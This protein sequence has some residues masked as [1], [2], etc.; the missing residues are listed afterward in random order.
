MAINPR[1]VKNL[2]FGSRPSADPSKKQFFK[3]KWFIITAIVVFTLLLVGGAF[4]YRT[5]AVLSKTNGKSVFN[6]LLGVIPGQSEEVKVEEDGRLNILLLGMRGENIPG[7]GLLA[8]SIMLISLNTKENKMAMISIP[9]DL[10]VKVPG[11]DNRAKINAVHA[12]GE[13]KGKGQGLKAM[14]DIIGQVTGLKVNYAVSIN[15]VGFKQLIDTVGGVPINLETP[16]YETHQFVEGKECGIEFNLPKGANVLNG[17]MALCYARAR[18]NTSDFDRSKRQQVILLALKE[19]L[20]SMGT[21]TDF[22][23]VNEILNAIGD[24]VRTDLSS[25]EMKSLYEKYSSAKDTQPYR[26][27]LENSEEGLLYHPED[28]NGAGYIL[29]PRAGEDNYSQIHEM[30]QNIYNLPVQSDIDPL[31]QHSKPAATEVNQDEV[32]TKKKKKKTESST[33]T[34]TTKTTTETK[35]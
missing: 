33:N 3:K 35:Q 16:F 23:K 10:Y 34:D 9:R 6:N 19:K 7:G 26:R 20:M 27:V 12:Y 30:C 4:A 11:S 24:N 21:L 5:G 17:E 28:S 22:G 29:L 32:K 25:S 8:D 18:D 14:E 1:P 31:K 13:E 2:N 15:F